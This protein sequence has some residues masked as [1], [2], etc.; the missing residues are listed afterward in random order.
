MSRIVTALA[1]AFQISLPLQC[2]VAYR[3][4]KFAGEVKAM[5]VIARVGDLVLEKD[6]KNRIFRLISPDFSLTAALINGKQVAIVELRNL[7]TKT[8]WISKP[9]PLFGFSTELN[10]VQINSLRPSDDGMT[11]DG[12]K[13]EAKNG[14]INLQF[15]LRHRRLNVV[16]TTW[17]RAFDGTSA[18]ETGFVIRNEGTETVTING[19]NSLA[20][21]IHHSKPIQLF[22]LTGGR[23]DGKFPPSSFVMTERTLADGAS[24]EIFCGD[25]G[26]SSARD[27]AWF[28][29]CLASKDSSV[30]EGIVGG[31]E[32]SGRWRGFIQRQGD[33]VTVRMGATEV[34]HHL[35]PNSEII[36]PSSFLLLF[37][38][39]LDD[40][41]WQLHQ[42]QEKFLC[43]SMPPNFPWVQ[44]NSWFGWATRIDEAILMREADIAAN[45]GCEVFVVDAGWY[46]GCGIG[47][48]GHGLGN[49]AENRGK[50]PK[51]LKALSDYVHQKGMKFGLWVEPERVDLETDL[52]KQHPDW[53]AKRDGRVIGG[54]RYAHLCFGNPQVVEWFKERLAKVIV[55]YGV[56]WLKWDYNIAYGLGCND[57]THGHQSGNGTYAHTRG[58]YAVKAFLRERFPHLVIEGCASGG[59]RIDFGILRH[60]HTYWLS[61]F[62]HRAANVRFHLTGAWF[63]LPPY[64]LNTWVVHEG[65]TVTEFR[66][67]MGG[68]FGIS[69]RLAQWDKATIER[70]KKCIAEYK[71]LRPFILKRRFLLTP[72]ARSLQDWTIWQ[73]H[74]PESDSG[75]IL[76][77][78]EQ[79]Q[80]ER[81]TVRLK[82]LNPK[83]RYELKN[84]DTDE[85]LIQMGEQ[86]LRNGLTIA[87]IET[88]GSALWWVKGK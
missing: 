23:Y 83:K 38:G 19:L 76:A 29:L 73:F 43:P 12:F 63:A 86:L 68:A 40:A 88:G 59:N 79:S 41:G 7:R 62:T 36:S 67:R 32:W 3:L 85:T 5:E 13:H 66:S 35:K 81:I 58:L 8:Q 64:Y 50:F 70:A 14:S 18:I 87:I 49:W 42:W 34:V 4:V 20:L 77:F 80:N 82:G 22:T 48:F 61:D 84:A 52:A 45:L 9:V 1:I 17:L 46:I 74:D 33:T 21:T 37:S 57:A 31:L 6:E 60:V 16:T 69:P 56:D 78:R 54:G 11:F 72:Q 47:D 75:A 25:E 28:A 51:G 39:D 15:R 44:F 10:G 53:L 2:I 30:T 65:T 26:R 71:R 27:I 55:D 24:C